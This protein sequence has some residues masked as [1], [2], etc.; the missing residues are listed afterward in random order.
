ME[1]KIL[2]KIKKLINKSESAEKIGSIKEAEAF[3]AKVQELLAKYNLEMSQIDFTEKTEIDNIVEENMK[4]WFSNIGGDSSYD[5]MRVVAEFNWCR[6]YNFG[7]HSHN[8]MRIIGKPENVE[9][10]KFIHDICCKVFI[11]ESRVAYKNYVKNEEYLMDGVRKPVAW[12]TYARTFLKGCS[13]G[14]RVKLESEQER[15]KNENEGAYGL[16]KVN[17]AALVEYATKWKSR[18]GRATSVSRIGD[19]YN[20]GVNVGRNVSINKG[21]KTNSSTSNKEI[22]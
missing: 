22:L 8:L 21:L 10:C 9:V 4:R 12:D 13:K 14:L 19:A 17:D 7:N 6:V 5:V 11:A 15:F 20:K 2:E 1:E 16:I 3:S 18:R